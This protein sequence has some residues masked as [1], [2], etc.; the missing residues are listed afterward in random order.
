MF[1]CFRAMG[2]LKPIICNT[3]VLKFYDHAAALCCSLKHIKYLS[4]GDGM[5]IIWDEVED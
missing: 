4:K 5:A 3:A 2:H 1:I